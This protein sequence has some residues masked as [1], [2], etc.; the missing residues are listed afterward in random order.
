MT[1]NNGRIR[2]WW[3]AGLA[4]AHRVRKHCQDFHLSGTQSWHSSRAPNSV[5]FSSISI[6][7]SRAGSL[8]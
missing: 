3:L 7:S 6:S 4:K 2:G 5:Y 8:F 1:I